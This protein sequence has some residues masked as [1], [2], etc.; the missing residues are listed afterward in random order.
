MALLISVNGHL[1]QR[2]GRAAVGVKPVSFVV[3]PPRGE[4]QPRDNPARQGQKSESRRQKQP[5]AEKQGRGWGLGVPPGFTWYQATQNR[6]RR[7]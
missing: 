1:G 4:C 5:G 7:M 2:L 6:K 3:P